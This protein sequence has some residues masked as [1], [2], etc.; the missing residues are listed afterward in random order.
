[1]KTL[2][3]DLITIAVLDVS[4]CIESRVSPWDMNKVRR[5]S[6][7]AGRPT[8]EFSIVAMLPAIRLQ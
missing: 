1:M 5:V 4:S 6:E 7:Y 2:N 3:H 8:R